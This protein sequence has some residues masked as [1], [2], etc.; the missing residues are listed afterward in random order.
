VIGQPANPNRPLVVFEVDFQTGPPALLGSHR[1]SV[2]QVGRQTYVRTW[3]TQRGRQYELD[4]VQAGL[5]T[6]GMV[7][8]N[9]N[10]NP[11]NTGSPYATG[12]NTI[13]PYHPLNISAFWPLSGNMFNPNVNTAYDGSFEATGSAAPFGA[14]GGGTA[15]QST[16]QALFGTHS[17]LVTQAGNSSAQ[18]GIVTVPGVPGVIATVS[19]YAYLTGGCSLQ[20][21]GPD[22]S[23]SAV[24]STQTTWTRIVL[25]Y[26]MQDARDVITFAGTG[27]ATPTYYLDGFQIEFASTAST[28]TTSGPTRFNVYNGY[29]ERYPTSY[30]MA[31][32]RGLHQL[33]AVDALAVLSRTAINQSY[34]TTINADGPLWHAPLNNTTP[35][36]QGTLGGTGTDSWIP[37]SLPNSTYGAVQWGSDSTLDGDPAVVVSQKNPTNPVTVSGAIANNATNLDIIGKPLSISTAAATFECWFKFSAG[38]FG[39]FQW[40]SSYNDGT[41]V[42]SGAYVDVETI[43]GDLWFHIHDDVTNTDFEVALNSVGS[44][45]G[46]FPDNQWHY[47]ALTLFSFN[48]GA[49]PLGIAATID[50]TEAD[51][52]S[53]FTTTRNNGYGTMHIGTFTG[54]GDPVSQG[55]V[56][57]VAVYGRDIGSTARRNHYLRGVGYINE[58]SGVRVRRLLSS[59]WAGPTNIANGYLKMA[60]DFAYNGRTLLDVIQEIQETERGL[61]YV[62]RQGTVVFE[63]RSSRYA[64][65]VP[66]AV[67]GENDSPYIEY[68]SDFDP[69]YTFSQANLSRPA[70]DAFAPVV[71]STAQAKYGQRILTQTLQVN[72]DFDLT[73]AATFYL[74]RYANPVVRITTLKFDLAANPALFSVILP[75]DIGSRVT[76]KR[77]TAALSTSNDYYV[78]QIH[79]TAD[80]ETGDWT[81]TLQLSPV[82]VN[83]AWVLGDNTYGILGNGTACVY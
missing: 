47:A 45:G 52:G 46:Y 50:G 6:L 67:F 74:A 37:Y 53:V 60:P 66:V 56:A 57:H 70:N 73:Q 39:P 69:T 26:V 15:A 49:P 31:G 65:Q 28:F 77:K 25:T 83:T 11:L 75:L 30:D 72:T 2:N 48:N 55:S 58:L 19:V 21:I 13:T 54:F 78:E 62:S 29:V 51:Y 80:A 36:V 64:N 41:L 14:G 32:T 4:Q 1:M 23:T 7:D 40:C 59:Y 12:G 35:A 42:P 10:L 71:N 44:A 24:L 5:A 61:L 9:E 68:D 20:I 22:G 63:D 16:A 27:T 81:V 34:L 33:Q 17:L 8:E 43:A 3:D 76:V 79:H 38:V 18:Y 82:F